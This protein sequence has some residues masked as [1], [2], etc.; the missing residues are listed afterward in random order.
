MLLVVAADREVAVI[1]FAMAFEVA[2]VDGV[3][4]TVDDGSPAMAGFAAF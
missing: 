1:V 2:P 3:T 4:G